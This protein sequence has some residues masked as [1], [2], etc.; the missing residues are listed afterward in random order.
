MGVFER[1][2]TMSPYFLAAFAVIFILFMVI[3]DMDPTSLMQQGSNPQ[4][5]PIAKVNG[6][7]ITYYEFEKIVKQQLEQQRNQQE[8]T[9]EEVEID[10]TSIRSQVWQSLLDLKL[11]E[12][13]FNNMGLSTADEVIADQL[14]NNPPQS[15][16]RMFADST[17]KFNRQMYLDIVTNPDRLGQY[18][19]QATPERKQQFI[20]DFR[21]DLITMG[22]QIRLQLVNT[23]ANNTLNAAGSITSPTYVKEKYKNENSSANITYIQLDVKT[24]EDDKIEVT[25]EELKEY[26]NENKENYKQ[27]AGRKLKYVVF[28]LKPSKND[29]LNAEKKIQ[30]VNI[31]L[32]KAQDSVEKVNAF[33]KLVNELNGDISDYK[34]LK[35]LDP[36]IS[37][38]IADAIPGKI[39]GPFLSQG[40][41][42]YLMVNNYREGENTVVK[43]SH[44]L[45]STGENPEESK[46]KAESILERAKNGEEFAALAAEYSDD[47]GTATNGGDLGWFGKG[48]MVAPFEKAAMEAEI[49]VPT[50]IVETQ[51]GYHIILVTEKS[52]KEVKFSSIA[53]SPKLTGATKNTIKRDALSFYTQVTEGTNF[54]TL[55]IKLG[56]SATETGFFKKDQTI[57]GNNWANH[58]AFSNEVGTISEPQEFDN[59]GIVVLMV[60][61]KREKGIIPF[62]DKKSEL[63]IFVSN[64]KKLDYLKP[65]AEDIAKSLNSGIDENIKLKYP[66]AEIK[67][68]SIKNNGILSGVSGREFAVTNTAFNLNQ[69]QTSG[70]VRGNKG[71]YI[72]QLNSKSIPNEQEI[73]DNFANYYQTQIKN[74]E[75]QVYYQWFKVIKENAE[76][77]DYRAKYYRSY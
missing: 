76:I 13:I 61:G 15:M 71:Y 77:E 60:S 2:R 58:F 3:A 53:I 75:R 25:E 4:T 39:I 54:D 41:T 52:S 1:I 37:L 7:D 64:K 65:I 74:S 23:F 73:N 6:E 22:E 20:S 67:T 62:E 29:T 36:E 16:R 24:V 32:N 68:T 47:Q 12:Q 46:A 21:K 11:S 35:D 5:A 72:V 17:G 70:A 30:K 42:K 51:F 55:A 45:I 38:Y 44:I 50:D 48:E 14:I 9:G 10:E 18:I 28:P 27:D 40:E 59:Y 49:G 56:L 34:L 43:A 63:E 8:Q 26:Y 57:L 31:A 33:N 69:G 66:K 19:G